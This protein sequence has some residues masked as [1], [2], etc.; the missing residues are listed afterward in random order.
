MTSVASARHE[1]VL[2]LDERSAWLILSAVAGVGPRT[3]GALVRRFGSALRAVSASAGDL[4]CGPGIGLARGG[5]LASEFA[6]VDPRA[7][8]ASALAAGLRVTTPVDTDY[9]EAVRTSVDPPA[10]LYVRGA[11]PP[12]D[13]RMVAIVGTRRASPYGLRMARHFAEALARAGVVVVSGLARGIDGA[14]HAGALAGGG[15]TV[16]VLGSGADIVYPPEHHA[17]ASE[18][19]VRGALVSE[20]PPGTPPLPSHFLRRNRIVAAMVKAVLVVEA[21]VRSGALTTARLATE[22]GRDVLAIPGP[23]DR[24]GHAGCHRLLRDGAILCEAPEDVLELIGLGGLTEG[25][26]STR[27][28]DDGRGPR[29]SGRRPPTG[30]GGARVIWDALDLDDARD[31]DDLARRTGLSPDAVADALTTLEL[32]GLVTRM[33]GAGFLR[34]R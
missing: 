23:V 22:F 31:A 18:V 16:A 2:R 13:Q 6:A 7:L 10:A 4:A 1:C 34:R 9:P 3:C 19:V 25:G 17:L 12:S 26:E 11:L 30:A 20:H 8:E 15:V 28:A 33:P 21:P 27:L 32:D 24:G 14:A 5:A 29:R